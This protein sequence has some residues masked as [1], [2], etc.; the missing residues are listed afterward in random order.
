[1]AHSEAGPVDCRKNAHL[2]YRRQCNCCDCILLCLARME[3]P[4]ERPATISLVQNHFE[5]VPLSHLGAT[6][7][8][9]LSTGN[10]SRRLSWRRLSDFY[11]HAGARTKLGTTAMNSAWQLKRCPPWVCQRDNLGFQSAPLS[12]AT[13]VWSLEELVGLL[14]ESSNAS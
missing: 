9:V 12:L 7:R 3:R 1:M 4:G 2:V 5:V 14:A 6:G 13:H 8:S 11:P 10:A